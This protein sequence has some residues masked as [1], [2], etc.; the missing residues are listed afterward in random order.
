MMINGLAQAKA[1]RGER[2][3]NLSAGEPM[4]ATHQA[5]VAAAAEAMRDEKTHYPPVAGIPELRRAATEW[6][7]TK[8]GANFV[9]EQCVVTCGGKFGIYAVCQALIEPGDEAIMLAPYWVSYTGI[10]Q[11]FGGKSVIVR[12][13]EATGWKAQLSDLEKVFSKKTK[14]LFINNAGNPTGAL[15]SRDEL[16]AILALAKQHDV[17]VVSDEVY[18][19]LT[20]EGEFASAA[21]F[22]EYADRVVLIQSCSK[23]FAMTGWRVGFMFG[24]SELVKIVTM[25][26]SQSTTGTSSISQW[27]A[28]A[29]FEHADEIIPTVNAAM[30]ERRDALVDSLKSEFGVMVVTPAAGLYVFVSLTAL[31]VTEADSAAFCKRTLEEGNV[32]LV[33]GSAF[34]QEGYV[35][36]SFGATVSEL[37][38]SIRALAVF[39]QK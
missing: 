12:A 3:Y 39:L 19:G 29:A 24:P 15:Y 33:P 30:R 1:A 22:P 2:V 36:L 26:Q 14:L 8:Y 32:A 7:R 38:A 17:V 35:R 11:L 28:L 16:A 18:S 25:L 27:A 9:P 4:V 23:H 6:M 5:V 13:S 37:V 31:G 20:Y 21:S 10:V 34:G